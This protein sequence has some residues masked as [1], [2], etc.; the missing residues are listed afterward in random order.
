[1]SLF[2]VFLVD[3][4]VFSLKLR[5]V[6]QPGYFFNIAFQLKTFQPRSILFGNGN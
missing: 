4:S 3:K 5:M 1:M 6:D 2:I